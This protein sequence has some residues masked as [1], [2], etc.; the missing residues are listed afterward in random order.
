MITLRGMGKLVI[1]K[2]QDVGAGHA[3]FLFFFKGPYPL[4]MEVPRLGVKLEA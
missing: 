1:G 2:G 3:L 4:H